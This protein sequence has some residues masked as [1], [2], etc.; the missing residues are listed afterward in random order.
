[1]TEQELSQMADPEAL[2]PNPGVILEREFP[3]WS[4]IRDAATSQFQQKKGYQPRQLP[5]MLLFILATARKG[6]SQFPIAYL[7]RFLE[8]NYRG[9]SE[10]DIP[11]LM[12]I[13]NDAFSGTLGIQEGEYRPL[14]RQ[15]EDWVLS[16][17]LISRLAPLQEEAPP[18]EC[19]GLQNPYVNRKMIKSPSQFWGRSDELSKIF[20]RIQGARPQCLSIVGERRIGKSSLLWHIQNREVYSRY[21]SPPENYVFV[22]LDFQ[23]C[24]ALTVE[25]FFRLFFQKLRHNNLESSCEDYRDYSG[26]KMLAESFE[27][28]GTRLL[29]L[30][31]EFDKVTM[32]K[33]FDSEFFSFLR[34]MANR[35]ELAFITSSTKALQQLCSSEEISA[36]PFFNIFTPLYLS[37]FKADEAKRFI[38]DS[39]ER[40]GHSLRPWEDRIIDFGGCHPFFLQIVCSVAFDALCG[41]SGLDWD[42]IKEQFLEE[43]GDHFLHFW[44]HMAP[45]EKEVVRLVTK[46]EMLLRKHHYILEDMRKRGIAYELR[47]TPVFFAPPFAEFVIERE[48]TESEWSR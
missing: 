25:E 44:E 37:V 47:S 36:S 8:N 7:K 18:R 35:F 32:S 23:E 11:L 15:G 31:D 14:R 16:N 46:R 30:L 24:G 34:S 13:L 12:K 10:R 39:S 9:G 22:F 20:S 45:R 26:F 5:H 3:R 38:E 17:E 29:V 1:M 21:L 6:K 42:C 4:L 19:S 27:K 33:G 48:E 43:A 28:S 41:N 2:V 40:A